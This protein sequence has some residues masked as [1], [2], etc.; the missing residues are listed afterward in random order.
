MQTPEFSDYLAARNA[1]TEADFTKAGAPKM[2]ALNAALSDLG[3]SKI[4]NELRDHFERQVDAGL[5]PVESDN[6]TLIVA[7]LEPAE[8]DIV[9]LI[10][11]AAPMN[12][13][14]CYVHGVGAFTMR[15]GI[16]HT[17]PKQ[18]AAILRDSNITFTIKENAN[19]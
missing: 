3:F 4:E 6:V 12:P 15:H 18:V 16:E 1:L 7:G 10:I 19:D 13:V 5:E 9:T 17:V 11:T 8:S 14:H 2:K